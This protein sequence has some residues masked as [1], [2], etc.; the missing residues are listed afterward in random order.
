MGCCGVACIQAKV[1]ECARCACCVCVCACC[2][3]TYVCVFLCVRARMHAS[4]R[5]CTHVDESALVH[6]R[7]SVFGCPY[8][9]ELQATWLSQLKA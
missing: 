8:A 5:V 9:L 1:C 2:V 4:M 3:C 7:S 6:V